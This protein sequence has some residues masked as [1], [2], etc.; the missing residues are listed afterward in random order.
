[1]PE[2]WVVNLVA[3]NICAK[4]GVMAD[5]Y[6][7]TSGHIYVQVYES[8]TQKARARLAFTVMHGL[9]VE[10][11]SICGPQ[12]SSPIENYGAKRA[13]RPEQHDTSTYAQSAQS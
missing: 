10:R 6:D 7:I 5:A 4:E 13:I 8:L 11:V 2:N 9:G 12:W 1:M 3:K